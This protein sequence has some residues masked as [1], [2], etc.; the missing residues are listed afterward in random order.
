M[1]RPNVALYVG[2]M[3]AREKN[4]Y[5]SIA[6]KYGY[7]DEATEIQDLY[8]SGRKEEAATKVPR[9]L[10]ANTNLVGPESHVAERIA[11]YKEAGVTHLSVNPI[12]PDAVKTI[13]TLR[14]LID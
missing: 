4:F 3:G 10:L 1:A 5:N 12:G 13:E 7:V 8:L 6:K 11:A 14:T 9:Q 2:G